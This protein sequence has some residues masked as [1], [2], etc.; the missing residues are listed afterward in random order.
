M[1]CWHFF[2]SDYSGKYTAVVIPMT[3]SIVF[4]LIGVGFLRIP[5]IAD[6]MSR[7]GKA[8]E[9]AAGPVHYGLCISLAT[10]FFWKRIEALYCILPISFGDG[11]AAFFGP[12]IRGNHFLSWN[13][14]KTWFG[15]IAF[16]VTSCTGLVCYVYLF[17]RN[18]WLLNGDTHYIR[19][20][21]FV[22]CMC[23]LTESVTVANYDNYTIFV[24]GILSYY[25]VHS[26]V[27]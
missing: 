9:L 11:F 1:L 25:Y 2:D 14:S 8:E 22:S 27:Y 24:M 16:I 17:T 13:P 26:L 5:L 12:R 10:V 19:N 20:A 15:L 6:A 3:F 23:G 18:G 21:V 7:S 4:W